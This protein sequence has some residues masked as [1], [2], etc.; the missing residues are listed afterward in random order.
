MSHFN[1]VYSP[2]SNGAQQVVR[3]IASIRDEF[4]GLK[5]MRNFCRRA[6]LKFVSQVSVERKTRHQR[7]MTVDVFSSPSELSSMPIIYV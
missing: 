3:I 6:E 1:S 5:A 2:S 4:H 7:A